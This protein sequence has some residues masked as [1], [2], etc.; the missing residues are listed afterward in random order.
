[1]NDSGF[2]AKPSS[3]FSVSANEMDRSSSSGHASQDHGSID[4]PMSEG[5]PP[6][7]GSGGVTHPSGMTFEFPPHPLPSNSQQQQQQRQHAFYRGYEMP[8]ATVAPSFV[9]LSGLDSAIELTMLEK[10]DSIISIESMSSSTSSSTSQSG[11]GMTDE[12]LLDAVIAAEERH[13]R[14]YQSSHCSSITTNTSSLS[15]SSPSPT[16]ST[17]SNHS[18]SNSSFMGGSDNDK[19]TFS[20][21]FPSTLT[22]T[23]SSSSQ[24]I[25]GSPKK[26]SVNPSPT[27]TTSSAANQKPF[28]TDPAL[29]PRAFMRP[30][31]VRASQACVACRKR[32]VRCV[33]LPG[34]HPSNANH[35]S[36]GGSGWRKT[37]HKNGA[38][39]GA[40][41]GTGRN[42]DRGGSGKCCT[43]CSKIGIDCVWAEERRG[44]KNSSSSSAPSSSISTS[45]APAAT[46]QGWSTIGTTVGAAAAKMNVGLKPVKTSLSSSSS[47]AGSPSS[48]STTPRQSLTNNALSVPTGGMPIY[49]YTPFLPAPHPSL[50]HQQ[51]SA[52]GPGGDGGGVGQPLY[53]Q[54]LSLPISM[55]LVLPTSLKSS[56]S[57]QHPHHPQPPLPFQ[58][59]HLAAAQAHHKG[60][61]T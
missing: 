61:Q 2:S 40:S 54:S 8:S 51:T 48:N 42:G 49:Q 24:S 20:R 45:S 56:S 4:H 10:R 55:K 21:A 28:E 41:N 14:H 23:S 38:S 29:I 53:A 15:S 26:P 60:S 9:S 19:S 27:K 22:P 36:K 39:G 1:M 7:Y 50:T 13:R 16:S 12:Q 31:A 47:S 44:K 52:P 5:F 25:S 43:R 3:T 17:F 6:V 37:G 34:D 11:G 57:L 59:Q 30:N 46:G 58:F 33:P 18:T 32:K 35:S